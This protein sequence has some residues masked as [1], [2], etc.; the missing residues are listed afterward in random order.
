M[1]IDEIIKRYGNALYEIALAEDSINKT[2]EELHNVAKTLRESLKLKDIVE[3]KRVDKNL[4]KKIFKEVFEGKIQ[5]LVLGYLLLIIDSE[6]EK[7][8]KE[9]IKSY[10]KTL[11]SKRNIVF[12]DIISAVPVEDKTL[13]EIK[14]LLEK[15]FNKK[16]EL[17]NSVKKEIL[18]G[19]IIKIGDKLIDGSIKSKLESFKK[20]IA[21]E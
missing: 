18:G 16:V 11:S 12:A 3:G 6:K 17:R 15:K 10:S 14:E 7:Y 5:P 21:T 8:L 20:E 9:I 19:L 2:E 4:K 13:N 1:K